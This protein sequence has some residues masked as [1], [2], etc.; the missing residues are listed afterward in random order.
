MISWCD[1]FFAPALLKTSNHCFQVFPVFALTAS[2]LIRGAVL[3]GLLGMLV[4]AK[5]EVQSSKFE[6]QSSKLSIAVIRHFQPALHFIVNIFE[7]SNLDAMRDA[8][9]F[10]KPA[11]VNQATFGFRV[12]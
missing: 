3:F 8:I 7:R 5:F 9:L 11:S 10:G 6:V 1:I 2:S 4:G 12:S